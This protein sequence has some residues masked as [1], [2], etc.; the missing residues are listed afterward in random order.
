M[1]TKLFKVDY[2][3]TELYN[4]K[5]PYYYYGGSATIVAKDA[6]DAIQKAQKLTTKSSQY[7]DEEKRTVKVT[8]KDF[9]ANSVNLVAQ[10]NY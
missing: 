10:T 6:L 2:Q 5:N 7:L 1:T 4:G 8:R 9:C 3:I